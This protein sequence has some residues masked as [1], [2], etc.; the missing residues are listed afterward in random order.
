MATCGSIV[1]GCDTM[2]TMNVNVWHAPKDEYAVCHGTGPATEVIGYVSRHPDGW[3]I[4]KDQ[5]RGR[6]LTMWD[7]VRALAN[8]EAEEPQYHLLGQGDE[9]TTVIADA[10]TLREIMNQGG[11]VHIASGTD[12]DEIERKRAQARQ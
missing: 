2:A 10:D 7:A 1:S 4:D 11:W 3:L 8:T 9:L 12:A 6:F 5:T